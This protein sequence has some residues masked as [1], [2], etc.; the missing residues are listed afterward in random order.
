MDN[1]DMT[2]I[3][4]NITAVNLHKLSTHV[5]EVRLYLYLHLIQCQQPIPLFLATFVAILFPRL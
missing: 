4:I 5:F 2:A 1:K 3:T